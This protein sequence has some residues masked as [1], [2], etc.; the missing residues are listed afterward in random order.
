MMNFLSGQGAE[1]LTV[2][3]KEV[4]VRAPFIYKLVIGMWSTYFMGGFYCFLE[5]MMYLNSPARASLNTEGLYAL[6]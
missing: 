6:I 5:N 4:K 1:E 2:Y 3:A